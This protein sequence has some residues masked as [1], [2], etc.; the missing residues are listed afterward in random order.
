MGRG[1]AEG[2]GDDGFVEATMLGDELGLWGRGTGMAWQ[3]RRTLTSG[4]VQL[5]A[6]LGR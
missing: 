1:V 5:L 2:D 3:K 4:R 6:M